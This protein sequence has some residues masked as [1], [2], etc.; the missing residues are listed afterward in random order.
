MAVLSMPERFLVGFPGLG[1]VKRIA[2]AQHRDAFAALGRR[3]EQLLG[4][5]RALAAKDQV[6]AI[7][8]GALRIGAACLFGQQM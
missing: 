3:G 5:A 8:V 1:V 4:N 6:V 2:I 7:A